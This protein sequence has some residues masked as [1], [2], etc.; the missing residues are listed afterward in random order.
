MTKLTIEFIELEIEAP[1][2]GQRFYRDEDIPGFALRVTPKSKSFI[3]ERRVNGLNRRFTIGKYS[4]M[5]LDDAKQQAWI[6]IGEIAKGNDPK[7]GKRIN[8][9]RDITL[10]EVLHKFLE[11]RPLRKDTQRNYLFAI[12]RHFEDWLDIPIASISKD[13]VEQRH[14]ELTDRPN[15]LGTSGHGRANTAL[16]K[17]GA[18]INFASDRFGTDD[19][20]LIKT[21]P[22][23][24]LSV[25][26]AWHKIRPRQGIVPEH[27]LKDWYQA[28]DRLRNQVARDFLLFLLLTGMRSGETRQLKWNYVDFTNKILIVPRELTKSD[29]EHRLPLSDFLVALLKR[30]YAY[31]T[32]SEWV[33]Q[34]SRKSNQPIGR[35][36]GIVRSVRAKSGVKFTFHDLRRTFLT[37]GEKLQVPHYTLK[38]LVNHSLSND[39]TG[40]YLVLDIESLRPHMSLITSTFLERLGVNDNNKIKRME[41]ESEELEFTQ[42]QILFDSIRTL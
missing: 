19:E 34:S 35:G 31:R 21:N 37:M 41:V 38:S 10:R 40:K 13:M 3:L 9:L 26:R 2:T 18:L 8:T 32:N 27:K 39:M 17:L 42:L 23:S 36:T 12:N 33:F 5:S 24:R 6:M 14:R 28:V 1:K 4:E 7:T 22:V 16:K 20:P 15:R 11:T 25:N 30:R 29:R